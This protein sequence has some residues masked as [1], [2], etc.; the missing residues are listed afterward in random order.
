MTNERSGS[1]DWKIQSDD[2]LKVYECG[3]V[4]AAVT[5]AVDTVN[6]IQTKKEAIWNF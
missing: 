6:K 5:L 1:G 2:T 4:S 3:I